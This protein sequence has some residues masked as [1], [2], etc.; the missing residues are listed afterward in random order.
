MKNDSW[1][2]KEFSSFF[3][4]LHFVLSK[5]RKSPHGPATG[6]G[7]RTYSFCQS[8][9]ARMTLSGWQ[10]DRNSPAAGT[11]PNIDLH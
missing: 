2:Q 6:W 11:R 9:P 3:M 1:Y 10:S 8:A 4:A 7:Q 5:Q